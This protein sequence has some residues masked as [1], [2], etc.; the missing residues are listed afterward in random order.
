MPV[1]RSLWGAVHS[2][3]SQ[4]LQHLGKKQQGHPPQHPLPKLA[5][6]ADFAE[7]LRRPLHARIC[8]E[9]VELQTTL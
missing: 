5:P 9:K 3:H 2:T 6:A 4:E 7:S 1:P 8:G